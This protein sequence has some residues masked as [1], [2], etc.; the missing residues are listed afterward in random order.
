MPLSMTS[1]MANPDLQAAARAKHAP[2][3]ATAPFAVRSPK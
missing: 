3:K 2:A 1:G